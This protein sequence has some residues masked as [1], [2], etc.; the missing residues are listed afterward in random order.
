VPGDNAADGFWL[1]AAPV[2]SFINEDTIQP[3]IDH[4]P[5]VDS[6]C[7]VTGNFPSEA[8]HGLD[9]VDFGKTTLLSPQ[10]DL[11]QMSNAWAHYYRWY[12][13]DSGGNID[14][15]WTVDVSS[16]GGQSWVRVET[17]AR[18]Q[19]EW[20][21]VRINLRDF[22]NLSSAM[23]F[24]FVAEDI[25][26]PSVVEALIDDFQIITY[27]GATTS[28][29][30]PPSSVRLEQNY[31]NPFNPRTTISFVVTP[32]GDLATLRVYDV[33]GRLV[34]TLLDDEFVSGD[35]VLQWDGRNRHGQDVASGVYFYRLVTDRFT[36]TRKM[37]LLK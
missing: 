15:V 25:G 11:S 30:G 33:S 7:F 23:Q 4:T 16:D 24:R 6:L 2:R 13:N 21:L 19:R 5:G 34:T 29:G 26:A 8:S 22:V 17:L 18:S 9:D 10:Y 35:R 20:A 27:T 37:V 12:T 3:G 14:D 31:P 1:R 32:P 36:T 28:A